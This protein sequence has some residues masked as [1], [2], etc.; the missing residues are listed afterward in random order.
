M[1]RIA[2]SQAALEAI[3]RTL[4]PSPGWTRPDG[5]KRST[6]TKERHVLHACATAT[7]NRVDCKA[8]AHDRTK[9]I[10]CSVEADPDDAWT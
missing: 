10:D 9:D 4:D 5:P 7:R 1:V 8:V 3:A 6:L 2:I